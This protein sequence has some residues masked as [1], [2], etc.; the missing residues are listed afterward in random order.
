MHYVV[1]KYQS[2]KEIF[3]EVWLI[4]PCAPLINEK[5]LIKAKNKFSRTNKKY[6]MMSFREYDAPIEWAF[7]FKKG[8]LKQNKKTN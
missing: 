5:D 1:N 8:L 3:D 6:S 4:Y 7:K 2:I